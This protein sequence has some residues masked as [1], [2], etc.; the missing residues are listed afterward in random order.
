MDIEV[1]QNIVGQPDKALVPFAHDWVGLTSEEGN[2]THYHDTEWGNNLFPG[3]T[4]YSKSLLIWRF[5]Q[6]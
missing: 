5:Q 6:F 1:D 3:T 4:S 2:G